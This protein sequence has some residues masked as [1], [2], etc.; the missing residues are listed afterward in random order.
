MLTSQGIAAHSSLSISPAEFSAEDV[1]IGA[2][3]DADN[4]PV[5]MV[6]AIG[7]FVRE[8]YAHGE[9][10]DIVELAPGDYPDDY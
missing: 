7:P 9:L 3:L 1:G 2:I 8:V 5:V 6:H 10:V 4:Q